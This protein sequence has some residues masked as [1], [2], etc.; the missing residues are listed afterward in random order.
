MSLFFLVLSYG[1]TMRCFSVYLSTTHETLDKQVQ[2]LERCRINHILTPLTPKIDIMNSIQP[3]ILTYI[4]ADIIGM[5][6]VFV[7]PTSPWLQDVIRHTASIATICLLALS[8]RI[9]N[10][11]PHLHTLALLNTT[12][13]PY[14]PYCNIAHE[15]TSRITTTTHG[16]HTHSN[17]RVQQML[18]NTLVS[19]AMMY[20]PGKRYPNPL[21]AELLQQ[22]RPGVEGRGR[23]VNYVVHSPC[24]LKGSAKTDEDEVELE[25]ERMR[26]SG[27]SQDEAGDSSDGT[28]ATA[29]SMPRRRERKTKFGW[30][31]GANLAVL[32]SSSPSAPLTQTL[33]ADVEAEVEVGRGGARARMCKWTVDDTIGRSVVRSDDT[34]GLNKHG[35]VVATSRYQGERVYPLVCRHSDKRNPKRRP[36]ANRYV[37]SITQMTSFAKKILDGKLYQNKNQYNKLHNR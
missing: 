11:N 35:Y 27:G 10:F 8:L 23:A 25:D 17:Y 12:M 15:L 26:L 4:L 1:V 6:L 22:L 34:R 9:T 28:G 37:H 20:G 33:D 24:K 29:L 14:L 21:T 36:V 32:F 2:I 5:W 3:A 31:T 7:A 16:Y 13:P 18:P 19:S 30:C